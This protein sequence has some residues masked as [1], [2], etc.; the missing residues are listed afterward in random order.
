MKTKGT[1]YLSKCLVSG[2]YYVGQ[3]RKERPEDRIR[4]HLKAE[5]KMH[6]H[7]AIRHHGPDNFVFCWLRYKN[8]P[9]WML[10]DLEQFFI[11]LYKTYER[12]YNMTPGGDFKPMDVPEIAKKIRGEN[13]WTKTNPSSLENTRGDN[14]YTKQPGYSGKTIQDNHWI[15]ISPSSVEKISGDNHYTKQPGYVSHIKGD[16]NPMKRAEVREKISGDKNPNKRPEVI[17]KRK[18]TIAEKKRKKSEEQGQIWLF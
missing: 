16:K 6:F 9:L 17:E 10:D 18:R 2:K 4:E 15:K 1:I 14:H 3:T 8:V 13:H 7:K 11:A 5:T 12:G